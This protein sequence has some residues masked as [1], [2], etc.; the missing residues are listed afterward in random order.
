LKN[1]LKSKVSD[2]MMKDSEFMKI[3]K[4]PINMLIWKIEEMAAERLE[5]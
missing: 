2:S 3:D 1:K 5:E 4:N